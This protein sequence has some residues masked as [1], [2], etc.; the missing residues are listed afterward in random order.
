MGQATV[1]GLPNGNVGVSNGTSFAAPLV[2]GLAAGLW[3][4]Y[5]QLTNLE[6]MDYLRRSGSQAARPDSL[7]GYGVPHFQRAFDL[8]A[9]DH[10]AN[11]PIAYLSPNPV[12]GETVTLWVNAQAWDKP[13]TVHVFDVT[14]KAVAERYIAR[15]ARSNQ[16]NLGTVFLRQGLYLVRLTSAGRTT[17]LKLVKQ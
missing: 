13:L 9:R 15:P 3:Q 17:M 4:A 14:G 5:P 11:Q 16:I 2:A 7:L 10:G 1:V 8:A 6:V 12:P